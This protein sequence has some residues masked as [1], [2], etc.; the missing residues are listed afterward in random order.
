MKQNQ[1]KSLRILAVAPSTRGFGFAVLETPELLVDW[2]TKGARKDKNAKAL[3]KFE[4]LLAQFQPD[5]VVL[6][7]VSAKDVRRA[8]RIQKLVE[9]IAAYSKTLKVRVTRFSPE[10][11]KRRLLGDRKRTKHDVAAF[12]AERFCVELGD[13]LPPKRQAWMSED[14]RV[15]IFEAVGLALTC[16]LKRI[17]ASGR[18][19]HR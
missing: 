2:G 19:N 6:P 7:D 3:Q 13:C 8:S 5:I 17:D 10:Q 11:I 15:D 16:L 14:R 1:M 9:Q 12:I 4:K 18:S